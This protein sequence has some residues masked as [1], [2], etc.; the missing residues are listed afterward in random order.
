MKA[1]PSSRI[2]SSRPASLAFILFAMSTPQAFA[3][4]WDGSDSGVWSLGT[5]WVGDAAPT[6][7]TAI[8]ITGS[9]NPVMTN[10]IS[11]LTTGAIN[12]NGSTLADFT[13][14]GNS[15]ILGGNLTTTTIPVAVP[16]PQF[17]HI[18]NIG[19]QLNGN[20]QLNAANFNNLTLNGAITE[21]ATPRNVTRGTGGGTINWNGA[22]TFSGTLTIAGSG[23][24]FF[25]TIADTGASAIGIGNAVPPTNSITLSGTGNNAGI[26]FLGT[27][28]G[29]TA[30]PIVLADAGTPTVGIVSIVNNS[31]DAAHALAL[32]GT[33]TMTGTV[34]K[35]LNLAGSNTG[36]NT[37]SGVISN[38]AAGVLS[39]TKGGD[40]TWNLSGANTFTGSATIAQGV[41]EVNTIGSV[42]GAASSLGIQASAAAATINMGN[43]STA[44]STLRYT[45]TT[46]ETT[47]RIVNLTG[48]T[49]GATINH[50]GAGVLRFTANMTA[51][52]VVA[53]NKT[54][55]LTGAGI[56]SGK[57][58]EFAG[59]IANPT[60]G[61]IITL[62]KQ[63]SGRWELEGTN[64][65]TGV[66]NINNGFLEVTTIGNQGVPS[67][68]GAGT[69]I[70]FGQG[71]A[72]GTLEYIGS[73]E[74]T[75]RIVDLK[76][77]NVGGG[78][79]DNNGSG[80]LIFTTNTAHT[81]SAN[82]KTLTLGGTSTGFI[83]QFNGI[84]NDQAAVKVGV[85]KAGAS[86]WSLGAAN[87]YTGPTVVSAG[88][89]LVNGSTSTGA[90]TVASSATLGGNGT[91]GGAT[92]LN[93]N[94]AP[95]VNVGTLTFSTGG[96]TL[97]DLA[98]SSLKFE[99]GANTT[100]GTTYDT[101]ATDTLEIGA[102]TLGLSD[103]QITNTGTLAPGSYTLISSTAAITG[104]LDATNLTGTIAPGF[105]GTL[106]NDGNNI[107]LTVAVAV[108]DPYT[109]WAG[110]AGFYADA[111]NDGV[112]NG[113]AWI[114]GAADV[115]VNA[116]N[117][118]PVP[119]VSGGNLTLSTFNRVNPMG[120]AKLFVEYSSNLT[121]W[122]PTET[123]TANGTYTTGNI[124]IIVAGGPAPSPQT[125]AVTV[126]SAAANGGRLF[127]RL[128]ATEN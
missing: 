21:D 17:T 85:T 35:T 26:R 104:T 96:L 31:A 119:T 7:S 74:T 114:L 93:G 80:A 98:A 59:V 63:D 52:N 83:N 44:T 76:T 97:G 32:S 115:S 116:L 41:L 70:G 73:G 103:F 50:V 42:A 43:G 122:T 6:A 37:I 25:N 100:A 109:D 71:T 56:A 54:F 106:T 15:I 87:T 38:T 120:N 66:T 39:L 86:T 77:S 16:Q 102:G 13:L 92:S 53:G 12:F 118:L 128:R 30:R 60:A 126:S 117:L 2:P 84:I 108:S 121:N 3:Q 125:V 49:G 18:I 11:G 51:T 57:R 62:N 111:N 36:N 95:G 91:V 10:D 45:G 67:N 20:R 64:T 48:T 79:I 127:A 89:L 88:T 61:G 5:N 90:V 65:Y 1:K 101:V 24:N 40:G 75:D 29:A 22:N 99:L 9:A 72:N 107:I 124:T 81:G 33:V 113:L 27:A 105:S 69:T 110:G 94:L 4:T 47:D 112:S 28:A 55:T 123:L 58:G 34:N 8:T 46:G 19:M 68:L 82:D 78:R 23:L 14:N